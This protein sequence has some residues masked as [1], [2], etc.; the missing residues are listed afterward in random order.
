SDTVRTE[1]FGITGDDPALVGDWDGDG[2]ADPAVYRNGG[3]GSQSFIFF[4]GSLNNPNGNITFVPWGIGG[5]VPV[6]GDFD[7]DGK[8]DAAV[9]RSSDLN[10]Y[11]LKSSNQQ[12]QVQ[13]WG[14][15]TDKRIEGDFDGD[16][17]TDFAVFRPSD[18]FWY[19][20]RSSDG[21][22]DIRRWGLTGDVPL[23]GDYDGDGKS[24]LAVWRESDRNFWIL[25]SGGSTQPFNVRADRD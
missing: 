11:I 6:R 21:Q 2:K 1:D 3:V 9:F 13:Q 25:Q 17:K 7:G 5:D 20:L 22:L 10:W 14:F 8:M 18:T 19:I 4:R 24:D 15:A 12:L 16:G 23:Q